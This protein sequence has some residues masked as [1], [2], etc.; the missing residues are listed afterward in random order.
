MKVAIAYNLPA[1]KK[2]ADDLDVL[3]QVEAVEKSLIE[4]GHSS[5]P[6]GISLDLQSFE[7]KINE[8]KPDL[9][10]N[11]VESIN[12]VEMYLHFIPVMLEKLK[13][14][15]TGASAEALFT[16]TNKVFTKRLLNIFDVQTPRWITSKNISDEVNT[17]TPCII[18]PIYEDASVG[19][20][21]ASIVIDSSKLQNEF[22]E[23]VKKYGECFIE[24]FIDDSNIVEKIYSKMKN[25]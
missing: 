17:K 14:V 21:D 1:N 7:K 11:L 6:I 8:V 20:D 3:V 2:S 22:K 25:K 12:G 16:T 24:E 5:I 19:L 10:F 13:I 23:R 9:V 15:F 4:L 18:K